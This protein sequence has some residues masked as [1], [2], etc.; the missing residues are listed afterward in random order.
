[1]VVGWSCGLLMQVSDR[2]R[3]RG[4]K[5]VNDGDA[6]WRRLYSFWLVDVV[7]SLELLKHS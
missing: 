6:V 7:I 4:P 2:M 5:A 1:M 3:W